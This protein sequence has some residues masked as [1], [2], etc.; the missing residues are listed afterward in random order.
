MFRHHYSPNYIISHIFEIE[1]PDGDNTI[2]NNAQ[3]KKVIKVKSST[4]NLCLVKF[5]EE[6]IVPKQLILDQI[7]HAWDFLAAGENHNIF[8]YYIEIFIK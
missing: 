7:Y 8:V 1:N 2:M 3:I 5:I 6:I 4:I